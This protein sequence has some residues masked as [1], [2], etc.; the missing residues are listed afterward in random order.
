MSEIKNYLVTGVAGFIGSK[1]AHALIAMGHNVVGIDNL[2]TGVISAIPEGVKSIIADV[3]TSDWLKE[4]TRIDFDAILHIAGQ[5]GGEM[6]YED[7]VYDLQSN[8]QSTL[9]LLD[10][11][12]NTG[13]KKI[14]Y[15]STVS[16]YGENGKQILQNEDD[17]TAPKSFY[18]V[19]KLASEN[20]LRIYASQFG[21]DCIALR[22]FNTY[23]PGQNLTNLKQGMVSIY[24][25]QALSSKRILVK[26]SADRFR[27][28]VYIDDVSDAFLACLAP[29]ITGYQCLNISTGKKTTVEELVNLISKKLPFELQIEYQGS[30]PGDIHGYTGNNTRASEAIKWKPRTQLDQGLSM[31]VDWGL[32]VVR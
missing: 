20:Y 26:G 7:P 15:A 25:A 8:A 14:V 30:T 2:S 28:F 21:L 13:C 3:H 23:G 5:S 19:G 27:D 11:A 10:Y 31:M 24:L 32:E 29:K 22:L 4:V 9:L 16:V 18:G 12:R 17:K 6:S 1:V